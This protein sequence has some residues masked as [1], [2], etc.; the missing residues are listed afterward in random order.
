M[1]VPSVAPPCT[2]STQPIT[3][4][5]LPRG[6]SLWFSRLPTLHLNWSK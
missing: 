6:E 1:N 2:C 3:V 4:N 5:E